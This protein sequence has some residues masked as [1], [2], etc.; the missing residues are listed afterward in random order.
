M[1]NVA[2]K[3]SCLRLWAVLLTFS[4]VCYVIRDIIVVIVI[5]AKDSVSQITY[6]DSN[7][8]Y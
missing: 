3:A 1:T 4:T 6:Y 5:L 8:E 2:Y 7:G